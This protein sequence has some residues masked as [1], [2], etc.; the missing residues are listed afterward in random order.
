MLLN[1]LRNS[2]KIGLKNPSTGK[3]YTDKELYLL[4][5]HEAGHSIGMEHTSNPKDVMYPYLNSNQK[6]LTNNDIKQIQQLYR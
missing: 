4:M 2:I 6:T 3:Y 5:L 1:I